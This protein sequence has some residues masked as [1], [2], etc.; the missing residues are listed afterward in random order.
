MTYKKALNL[1]LLVATLF[2]N[3]F[4]VVATKQQA[5]QTNDFRCN[6]F[7]CYHR[8]C[9]KILDR[10][11]TRI[12]WPWFFSS[13]FVFFFINMT[14]LSVPPCQTINDQKFFQKF[15]LSVVIFVASDILL[16]C[17]A[18]HRL[19]YQL[20]CQSAFPTNSLNLHA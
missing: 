7:A 4:F 6:A 1:I 3:D 18:P 11:C 19:K 2:L 8:F 9:V 12:G 20:R 5:K 10:L 17:K 15:H 13:N 14:T 16:S